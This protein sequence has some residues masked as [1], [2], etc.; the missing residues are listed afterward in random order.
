MSYPYKNFR[1][2]ILEEEKLGN[3]LR[4]NAPIKCGDYSN[5][6]DIGGDVPGKI[7]E[8]ELRAFSCYLHSLPQKPIGI[9]E[10]PVNNRPDIPLV[11]NCWPGRERTLRALGCKD[12]EELAERFRN[13]KAKKIKPVKVAKS[14]APCKQVV[15]S[16]EKIDLRKDIPR[17]WLEN[18]QGLWSTCNGVFVVYDPETNTHD[19]GNWR[20]GQYEW[21]DAD[22]TK[23]FPEEILKKRMFATL[24][25]HG[26]IQSDG[27]KYYRENYRQRN[28]P[29]PV[30]VALGLPTDC[31]TVAAGHA[32][33]HWPEDGDEYEIL[34]GF[35]GEP[36]E[37]VESETIPGLMVPSQAEW[38]IEGEFLPEN[39]IMPPYAEDVASGHV[40]G[41]E[42]CPILNVKCITHRKDPWW[43]F[44]WSQ[45]GLNGHEGV[46]TGLYM[47][48]EIEALNHLRACG[49]KVK[50]IAMTW[51]FEV[52][53]VQLE[54]D[55]M[56]KPYPYYGRSVLQALISGPSVLCGPCS[57]YLIAVGPD[58]NPYDWSDVI[59]ALGTRTMPA[60]DSIIIEKGLCEWGDPGGLVGP[61]GWKLYGEQMMIDATIKIPERYESFLPRSE[62]VKWEKEAVRQ[63]REKIEKH[64]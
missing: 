38:V 6:V 22:P 50:D 46:H 26:P 45:S 23:P 20:S 30:A 9:I 25:Y 11:V 40:F 8:T 3:V 63:I 32:A 58:I 24:I 39:E 60:S 13:Y 37:V 35:R 51:D 34:G 33:W 12:K 42:G 53:V 31:H 18:Q 19:L 61:L 15:I 7:P 10:N 21:K 4:I 43:T 48:W 14:A 2:W 17:C 27:G 29:M 36:V 28:K 5:I 47:G 59:W 54:V 49:Y 64:K 16:E 52:V 57:K 55:G 44:T 41:G 62:P 56:M 1:E